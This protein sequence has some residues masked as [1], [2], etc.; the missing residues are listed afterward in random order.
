VPTFAQILRLPLNNLQLHSV[1]FARSLVKIS[2]NQEKQFATTA[3]FLAKSASSGAIHA[4]IR[5]VAAAARR[6]A[7]QWQRPDAPSHAAFIGSA[8]WGRRSFWF[9]LKN[10]L[11]KNVWAKPRKNTQK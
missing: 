7:V 9:G 5:T 4:Q 2:S 11:A 1:C 10:G 8:G 3:A 6:A